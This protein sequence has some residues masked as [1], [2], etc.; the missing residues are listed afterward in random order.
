MKKMDIVYERSRTLLRHRL[1]CVRAE[2]DTTSSPLA[3]CP[4]GA[5]HYFV[6]TCGVYER[7]RTLLR[8]RLRCVRAEPDTTSS[9]L[10]VCT[11]GAG[12][13]FVTACGVYERSRTLL[14]HRLR[15]VRAEP[16]TTSSQLAVCTSG[17][18]HYF[19]TACGDHFAIRASYSDW[20]SVM[21]PPWRNRYGNLRSLS[22][23]T[24]LPLARSSQKNAL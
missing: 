21:M 15:C 24:K 9:P 11:S 7:S 22:D 20:G 17:A 10:V 13:Y 18:G 8:H 16:D 6:T 2:P 12:H 19:V 4:S 3:V 5:G 14:R 23:G 1:R